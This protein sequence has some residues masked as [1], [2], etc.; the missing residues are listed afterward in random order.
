[1]R[2]LMT[3]AGLLLMGACSSDSTGPTVVSLTGNW[4][5][6]ASNVSGSGVSCNISGVIA[7]LTQTNNTFSGAISGG[8]V[9]CS[10]PGVATQTS[11]LGGDIV[12]NGHINGTAI[13]F[14]IGTSDYHNVGTISG[15]SISGT[16][17]LRIVES[18]QTFILTGQFAAVKQ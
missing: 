7:T 15:N 6:S 13:D 18:G 11:A 1:M 14:D 12:A 2:R 16:V 9:S 10:A 17:T 4:S 3:I 5:Y 8:T